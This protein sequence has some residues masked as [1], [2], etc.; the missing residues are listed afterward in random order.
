M[1]NYVRAPQ[2]AATANISV[3]ITN[4][5]IFH[6]AN[7]T[8]NEYYDTEY[9]K[10]G[11]LPT[12]I[13]GV[14]D[15]EMTFWGLAIAG[16]TSDITSTQFF[17]DMDP[18]GYSTQFFNSSGGTGTELP[19]VDGFT[20]STS[21]FSA[22]DQSTFRDETLLV[23][24]SGN[25][26][27][28]PSTPTTLSER[29]K[30]MWTGGPYWWDT[31]NTTGYYNDFN[32]TS[33][34]DF[35]NTAI[36][37]EGHIYDDDVENVLFFAAYGP[38]RYVKEF[39]NRFRIGVKTNTTTDY[40]L[41]VCV[42]TE[43]TDT[44]Y[45][46]VVRLREVSKG[47]PQVGGNTFYFNQGEDLEWIS[48]QHTD[49]QTGMVDSVVYPY[50]TQVQLS[51]PR[52]ARFEDTDDQTT[53]AFIYEGKKVPE[54][55]ANGAAVGTDA[56]SATTAEVAYD[57]I[58][59]KR[60]GMGEIVA[61]ATSGD[62]DQYLKYMLYDAKARCDE[63]LTTTDSTGNTATQSRYT[64][65]SVVSADADKFATATKILNN[66]HAKYYFHNG[67]FKIYQDKPQTPVKVVNQSNAIDIKFRGRSS[68]PKIN[69]YYVKYNNERK[70]FQQDIAFAEL[71]EQLNSGMPVVSQEVVMEG[72]TN[73]YQAQR[74][75]RYLAETER[76]KQEFVEYV[77]GADHVYLKPGDLVHVQATT[78]DGKK[79]SG[80]ILSLAN[81][82]VTIDANVE[83]DT[84]KSYEMIIDNAVNTTDNTFTPFTQTPVDDAVF[85]TAAVPTANNTNQFTL[86]ST[87]GLQD[88]NQ[89]NGSLTAY[90]RQTFNLVEVTTTPSE[91]YQVDKIY[92]IQSIV[93]TGPLQYQVVAQRYDENKWANIDAGFGYGYDIEEAWATT[94]TET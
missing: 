4:D 10:L 22:P 57:Y 91:S 83:V 3:T 48:T 59:N 84:T 80:R 12:T 25:L 67:F 86:L 76:N 8:M 46:N 21:Y 43:D 2:S 45:S 41:Q 72:I 18:D 52:P 71:R 1:V 34:L 29:Y 63:Q 92:R 77:A 20:K 89:D 13:Q 93:E 11:K 19:L 64:F 28:S 61:D 56:F 37:T 31:L 58:T 23:S 32:T 42:R 85:I 6:D 50:V 16:N 78:D 53:F 27:T 30:T 55:N 47:L 17:L 68:L 69:T 94:Y 9:D 14:D 82:V 40:R 73:K 38:G 65:N 5:I 90:N 44:A 62:Q 66:M 74:H 88:I 51:Y 26:F 35:A 7:A 24:H 70:L 15:W 60:Y 75:A 36:G 33:T 49:T 81:S 79:H 87:T 54:L 39:A